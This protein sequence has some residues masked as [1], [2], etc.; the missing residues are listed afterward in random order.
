MTTDESTNSTPLSS[1]GFKG[2]DLPPL[3]TDEPPRVLIAGAGLAGLFLGILLEKAGIPYEIFE[4]SSEIKPLGA[5]LYL[6]P[7]IMPAFEQLGLY[8]EH[9]SFSKPGGGLTSFYTDKLKVIASGTSSHADIVGYDPLYFA[10]PELYDMLFKKIPSEKIHMSK[11]ILSFQQN[12]EGVMLRFSDNTTIHGDILVG[13]DGAHSS[14]RQH[15]F[16]TMDKQG[17]LPKVDTQSMTKGYISLVGTTDAL[18]PAIYPCLNDPKCEVTFVI[19]DKNTPYTWVLFSIPGNRMCWNV[20]IQLGIEEIADDQFKSSDWVPQ[21]NQKMLDLLRDCKTPYGT[22][23]DLFDATPIERISKVYYEDMLFETWTHGR[24][25]L[26]GDAAHKLLPSSGAGAV[27]A[28]QDA[29]LLAN[30]LYD[31]KPTSFENIKLALNAYKEE[32]FD[33][34][35]DQYPQSYMSA[36][37]T[38]GHKLSERILRHIIFNWMPKS[39]MQRQLLKDSAYRPQANFLPLA[40]KRGTIE[41][42]PQQPS[43]RMQKEE[44]EA[45]K[46]AAAATAT[47]L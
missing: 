39:V 8:D 29:V 23:G 26:I 14:V 44:E 42:I 40:P 12:H 33:A 9:L 47:A 19:G 27:N 37:L 38:Y 5:I 7:A 13:A 21:Q 15:L 16:K 34:I 35:K 24:T 28:M 30:H 20:I 4:R 22:M 10:R 11:K 32:R 45:K 41:I 25:I 43:K 18:D 2:S 17:L 46:Q 3:V 36:K 1:E 6:S 31:I